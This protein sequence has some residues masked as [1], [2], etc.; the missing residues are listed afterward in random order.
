LARIGHSRGAEELSSDAA[1]AG[2]ISSIASIWAC[3]AGE[4]ALSFPISQ[5]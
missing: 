2:T 5:P 4:M 1:L 3:V